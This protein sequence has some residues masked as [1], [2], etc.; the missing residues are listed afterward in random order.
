MDGDLAEIVFALG[1]GDNVI[2]TD[3]SATYPEAA[4]D[5]PNI[6]YQRALSAEPIAAFEPTIVLAT[7]LAGPDETL[8]A[9]R[10]LGI[11]VVVI[12]VDDG[13]MTPVRKI[14]LVA[15][16]LGVPA[17]GSELAASVAD[18][19]DS[20]VASAREPVGSTPSASPVRAA[21]LYLRGDSTQLLLGEGSGIEPIL[22]AIG[23]VDVAREL[24]IVGHRQISA[25]ALL[26]AAPDV[27]VVTTTGLESV[28]GIDG[29]LAIPG[30]AETP[31]GERR[32]VLIYED[33]FL[34]GGGPRT[35][36]LV[37]ALGVDLQSLFTPT[38]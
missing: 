8:D 3:L 4:A 9:L 36:Q 26:L 20:A 30:I 32:A 29:L 22:T 33:Q 1:L 25:E 13:L 11:P 19:I 10:R 7:D 6:G 23:V 35:G 28:G 18:E 21:V 16:A 34:L 14:E 15:E 27:F 2:A 37:A 17:R 5:R 12:E 24:E 31:A 38:N